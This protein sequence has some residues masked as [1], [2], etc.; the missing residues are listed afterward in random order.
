MGTQTQHV[1]AWVFL[2]ELACF[3]LRGEGFVVGDVHTFE[4]AEG[5]LISAEMHTKVRQNASPSSRV[6]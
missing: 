3:E 1:I 6:E 5:E 4:T 2:Y